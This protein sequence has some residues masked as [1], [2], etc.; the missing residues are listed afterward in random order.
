MST[1]IYWPLLALG[2]VVAISV[3]VPLLVEWEFARQLRLRIV[4]PRFRPVVIAGGKAAPPA[5][6]DKDAA[7]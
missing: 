2:L 6:A 1:L 4:R 7:A 3:A 5:A